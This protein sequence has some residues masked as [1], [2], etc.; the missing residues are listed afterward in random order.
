MV[1][2]MSLLVE[3]LT[4]YVPKSA[5]N[6]FFPLF[7]FNVDSS[8][9]IENKVFKFSMLIIHIGMQGKVSQIFYLCPSFCFM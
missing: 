7:F 6:L 3:G 1:S 8:F 2:I 5:K 9:D 4:K